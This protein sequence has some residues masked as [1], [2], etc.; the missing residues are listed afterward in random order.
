M[1]HKESRLRV[2]TIL[3]GSGWLI[4]A[5]L[6][7]GL[8]HWL[9]RSERPAADVIDAVAISLGLW[10]TFLAIDQYRRTREQAAQ[11]QIIANQ[12]QSDLQQM[13][14]MVSTRH[15]GKFPNNMSEITGVVR[16]ASRSLKIMTDF[17]GYGFYTGA[18]YFTDYIA[19]LRT[20]SETIPVVRVIAFEDEAFTTEFR[21]QFPENKFANEELR[22]DRFTRF[23]AG[24]PATPADWEG[25][26]K[27]LTKQEHTFR[28]MLPHRCQVK[29][30]REIFPY[31]FWVSD[32]EAVLSLQSR[33][34][35]NEEE[36]FWTRDKN[37]VRI[38]NETFDHYWD[39]PDA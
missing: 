27:D 11:L 34:D 22:A 1:P 8:L 23:F 31:F 38:L 16:R 6:L 29:G 5:I 7:F 24:S 35:P 17:V 25:F 4:S 28:S 10:G 3:I 18:S 2:I 33:D 37:F 39:L 9:R 36:S 30:R 32:D 12:L 21:R 14:D 19:Q 15:A 13:A 26:Q 20:K